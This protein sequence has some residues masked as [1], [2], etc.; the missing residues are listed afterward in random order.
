[1][2]RTF[3]AVGAM[4]VAI[5]IFSCNG[6][7]LGGGGGYD[8]G[9]GG[10]SGTMIPATCYR[11]CDGSSTT[12]NGGSCPAGY[13]YSASYCAQGGIDGS[14]PVINT[15]GGDDGGT[16]V[17]TDASPDACVGHYFAALCTR[18]GDSCGLAPD[19]G[20]CP[21][22]YHYWPSYCVAPG[23]PIDGNPVTPNNCAVGGAGGGGGRGG[24]A[25]GRGGTGGIAG[26][27][28]ATAVDAGCTG[29]IV[30]AVCQGICNGGI[31]LTTPDGDVCPPNYGY[32]AAYCLPPGS[33]TD[34][35]GP[36]LPN[37]CPSDGAVDGNGG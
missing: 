4:G 34:G 29:N 33:H 3:L 18:D 28:G 11:T 1:M 27:G 35:Y 37:S 36:P 23:V 14:G 8:G 26:A 31:T 5:A 7:N 15:C 6:G 24:S 16:D 32:R 9:P 10:C 19:G 25:G 17:P 12:P 13:V 20:V 30:P 22:G 21:D 2:L